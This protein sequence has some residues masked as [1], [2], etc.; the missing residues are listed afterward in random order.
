MGTPAS[1][2]KN[3]LTPDV[4]VQVLVKTSGNKAAAARLL[5]VTKPTF[6]AYMKKFPDVEERA[7]KAL[8]TKVLEHVEKSRDI[9][10]HCLTHFK[11]HPRFALK[12]AE[13]VMRQTKYYE[14]AY[15][16][17][18]KESPAEVGLPS[19]EADAAWEQYVSGKGKEEA[20]D[21]Y[22]IPSEETEYEH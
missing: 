12:A 15:N 5:G 19:D 9:I 10:G 17:A 13:L 6:R 8:R 3:I 16:E 18:M 20:T 21:M 7:M 1:R 4:L 11:N 22:I 14:R 2:Y